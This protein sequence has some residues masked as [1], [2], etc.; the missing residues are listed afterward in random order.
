VIQ[1]KSNIQLSNWEIV[2]VNPNDKLWDWKDLFCFWAINIQTLIAFSL[3]ASLYLVYELNFLVVSLGCL[4][5]S[6]FVYL[7]ANLIGKPSQKHGIPF[8]V[9]LRI[10]MGING[11]R[12]ISLLRGFVGIFMFGVQTFFLSKSIGYLIRIAI[13]SFDNTMMDQNIFLIFYL[14]MNIVDGLS[15]SLAIILQFF[16]FSKGHSFNKTFI[17]F[18]AMFVYFGLILFLIIIV[19]EHYK[20]LAQS[21]KDLLIF[22]NILSK[23]N[24]IKVITIA[25]TIFAYFSIVIVNYGD[26]SRYVKNE[27]HLNRGN[28]SLILNLIIFSLFS[29]L[30]VVGADI[31]LNK[32]LQNMDKILTNP[33]DIIGQ[34]NNVFL[35]I[36]VLFFIFFASA[37]TNLIANYVPSQNSLLNFLP[38]KLNLK[39]SGIIIVLFGLLI[40]IFWAPLL[41]QIGVLSFVDTVGSFFGPIF[42]IVIIDYYLIKKGKLVNKDIFSSATNSSYYYSSGWHIKAIYSLFIGFIFSA[43]TIWNV[44]LRFLQ[45]FSWLIGAL[46][47]SITYFLLANR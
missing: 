34:F 21:F 30:I 1:E 10:S 32:N 25:G 4:I 22:E 8:P 9:F 2:S 41:S 11:A 37:S 14:G 13:Y 36:V 43:A 27:K 19:S 20:D 35:S 28:L 47:S 33:T 3:I 45:A 46:I 38:S 16:L 26:F 40:G 18:S 7:L 44:D 23:D 5:G 31:I 12:Y 15:I 17:N 24:I 6:L 39:S 42:G 29:V